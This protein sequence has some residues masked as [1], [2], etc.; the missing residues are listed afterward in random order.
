MHVYLLGRHSHCVISVLLCLQYLL[1]LM[2]TSASMSTN[3]FIGQRSFRLLVYFVCELCQLTRSRLKKKQASATK[4][5][6]V[7]TYDVKEREF[8]LS[9]NS[10]GGL[11][12][13]RNISRRGAS[14]SSPSVDDERKKINMNKKWNDKKMESNHVTRKDSKSQQQQRGGSVGRGFSFYPQCIRSN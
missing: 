10:T 9:G 7:R 1:N 11:R 5:C 14:V 3:C 2:R 13:K 8:L 12:L 4:R 6:Q